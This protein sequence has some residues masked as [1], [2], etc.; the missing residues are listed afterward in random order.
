MVLQSEYKCS[1]SESGEGF[2]YAPIEWEVV[3][4]VAKF[5]KA[6]LESEVSLYSGAEDDYRVS[7]VAPKTVFGG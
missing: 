4:C 6:V 3:Y 7:K 5:S 1:V 2:T